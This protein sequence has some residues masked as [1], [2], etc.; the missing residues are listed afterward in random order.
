M[1]D[2]QMLAAVKAALGIE[3]TYQDNTITEYILPVWWLVV[4]LTYGLMEQAAESCLNTSCREPHSSRISRRWRYGR[5][6]TCVSI[7]DSD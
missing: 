5:F 2:A 6:Q 1:T 7:F 4:S 3:G